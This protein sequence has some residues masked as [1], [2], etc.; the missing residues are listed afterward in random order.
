IEYFDHL[1]DLGPLT[2]TGTLFNVSL[3]W[4]PG[5]GIRLQTT[6]SLTNSVWEDVPGTL[7]QATANLVNDP[8]FTDP[9]FFRLSGP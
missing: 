6:T 9:G 5:P 7:G 4:T 8:S 3:S 2:I 1:S